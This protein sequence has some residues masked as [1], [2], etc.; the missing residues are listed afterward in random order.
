MCTCIAVIENN[1]IICESFWLGFVLFYEENELFNAGNNYVNTTTQEQAPN[2]LSPVGDVVVLVV[3]KVT[4]KNS[5]Y[6]NQ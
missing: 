3:V 4:I 5:L 1:A 2:F 6:T